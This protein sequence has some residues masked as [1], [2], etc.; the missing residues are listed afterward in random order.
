[1]FRLARCCHGENSHRYQPCAR[2]RKMQRTC[3]DRPETVEDCTHDEGGCA[4]LLPACM[5]TFPS[6]AYTNAMYMYIA[7][8]R[9]PIDNPC[10]SHD[11]MR[12]GPVECMWVLANAVAPAQ[13]FANHMEARIWAP[14]PCALFTTLP[15]LP[16]G[17]CTQAS[18]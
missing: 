5:V 16:E 11:D 15:R 12:K 3:V 10:S 9:C 13:I 2:Q 4:C 18:V 6:D 8:P 14:P 17:S 7:L 1:M